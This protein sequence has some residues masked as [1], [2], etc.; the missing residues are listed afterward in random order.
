MRTGLETI[1]SERTD[2]IPC[3]RLQQNDR[4]GLLV[5]HCA[6]LSRFEHMGKGTG[7]GNLRFCRILF[8]IGDQS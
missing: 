3:L 7:L 5:P 6:R 1:M 4:P 8:L 2:Y